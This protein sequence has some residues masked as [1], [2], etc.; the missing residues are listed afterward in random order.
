MNFKPLAFHLAAMPEPVVPPN[1]TCLSALP[2][3]CGLFVVHLALL[4]VLLTPL[5]LMSGRG[6]VDIAE[7][8]FEAIQ[9]T[10]DR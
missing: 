1:S 3:C 4:L 5:A 6:D 2:A 7:A 9:A 8:A 10:R